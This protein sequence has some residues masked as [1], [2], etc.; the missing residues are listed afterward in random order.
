M[1]L[2]I[3]IFNNNNETYNLGLDNLVGYRKLTN[4]SNNNTTTSSA[5]VNRQ[6]N[7]TIV[8]NNT[9]LKIIRIII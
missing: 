5:D 3:I 2:E 9:R 8:D 6:D 7:N 1:S 4:T